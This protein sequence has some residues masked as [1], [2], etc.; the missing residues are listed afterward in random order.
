MTSENLNIYMKRA[1]WHLMIDIRTVLMSLSCGQK[2]FS[3]SVA[4]KVEEN[5]E[6]V[7]VRLI[8]TLLQVFYNLACVQH[9]ITT[10]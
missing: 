7:L 1:V 3:S 10:L 4:A 6:N 2:C 8:S 9:E 5:I